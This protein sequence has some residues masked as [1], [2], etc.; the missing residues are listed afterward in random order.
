T[1]LLKLFLSN[2][3]SNGW[4]R[5]ILERYNILWLRLSKVLNHHQIVYSILIRHLP[6]CRG[7]I[8]PFVLSG[9]E[10]FSNEE[11]IRLLYYNK[12]WDLPE[13]FSILEIVQSELYDNEHF[14]FDILI[15]ISE[16]NEDA[17][18][19]L[20]QSYF[21]NKISS[22]E[23]ELGNIKLK[24]GYDGKKFL[25]HLYTNHFNKALELN[26]KA[27]TDLVCKTEM[28]YPRS[29]NDL[30]MDHAFQSMGGYR[31]KDYGFLLTQLEKNINKAAE[32]SSNI[33]YVFIK[34]NIE[35]RYTTILNVV[36]K[37]LKANP[38]YFINEIFEFAKIFKRRELLSNTDDVLIL[39]RQVIN[40]AYPHFSDDQ[41]AVLD[42]YILNI[43]ERILYRTYKDN[44]GKSKLYTY[45]GYTQLTYLQSIPKKYICNNSLLKKKYQELYRKYGVVNDTIRERFGM[46][47]IVGYPLNSKAYERMNIT[48]WKRSMLKYNGFEHHDFGSGRGGKDE[49]CRALKE[50]VKKEPEK[51]LVHISDF[52][53]KDVYHI[54]YAIHAVEGLFESEEAIDTDI[55]VRLVKQLIKC[56]RITSHTKRRV[57]WLIDTLLSDEYMD[58]ELFSFL[59]RI[60]LTD[61]NP[62][63]VFNPDA[64]LS[65][66]INS[67][68]GAAA[69]RLVMI[70]NQ[71][72]YSER[73][74][75]TLEKIPKD[76]MDCV[77][78][79]TLYR[80]AYLNNYDIERNFKLFLQLVDTDNEQVLQ[81]SIWSAQY[82]NRK[83]PN[84]LEPY[85]RKTITIEKLAKDVS[86]ALTVAWLEGSEESYTILQDYYPKVKEVRKAML[87]VAESNIFK[88]NND[89]TEKCKIILSE[90]LDE[91]D[92]DIAREYTFLFSDLSCEYFVEFRSFIA[93]YSKSKVCI[94]APGNYIKFLAKSSHFYPIECLSLLKNIQSSKSHSGI[95]DEF[96][97]DDKSLNVIINAYNALLQQAKKDK[98]RINY[99]LDIFDKELE[100]ERNN[101]NIIEALQSIDN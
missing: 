64:L 20:F 63:E 92:I 76:P 95:Q 50:A 81:S 78:A 91:D 80:I 4:L 30:I 83:Y 39:F 94:L 24:I 75:S 57:V 33:I 44:N 53:I 51:F 16:T 73:I 40:K 46:G 18:I 68:R 17:A 77:K 36:L 1:S 19:T 62:N 74:F 2:V 60:A 22:I 37:G 10:P 90:F 29:D 49:H 97:Y 87:H 35:S 7:L 43:K 72:D 52:I 45:W 54:D 32:E 34:E 8:L 100:S 99:T 11:L 69:K 26:L 5:V 28:Q 84:E 9:Q 66:G 12:I 88:H 71:P 47:T 27:V 101:S 61:N 21:S 82:F 58:D 48:A 25:T 59:A 93:K 15:Q 86:T 42:D 55:K 31:E 56:S 70:N 38:H 23:Y 79:A 89:I 98:K 6:E 3:N 96:Y 41:R 65:D 85:F 67:N 13:A 14:M